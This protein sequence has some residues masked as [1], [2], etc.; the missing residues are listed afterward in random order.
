MVGRRHF[1]FNRAISLVEVMVVVAVLAIM[2]AVSIPVLRNVIPATSGQT[3]ERNL[4]YL[5]GAVVA[6]NQASWELVLATA[7][8][9]S[10]EQAIFNS[11]RYR[12]AANPSPGSPYL[13]ATTVFVAS[14]STSD[15]RATWNGRMFEIAM[16]GASGTGI[17]LLKMSGVATQAFVTNTPV[18]RQ[19]N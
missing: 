12:D 16:P 18:P 4:N 19:T 17:N 8:G 7:S 15:Y 14:S 2:A 1:R 11:L 9:S 13:P 5:N 10:D 3:A 6:F